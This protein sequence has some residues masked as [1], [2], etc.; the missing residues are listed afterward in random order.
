MF[1]KGSAASCAGGCGGGEDGK[2]RVTADVTSTGS[3]DGRTAV[4][5][6][7]YRCGERP[8]T[9]LTR[10]ASC[11][12]CFVEVFRRNFASNLRTRCVSRFE[13]AQP[14]IL[15]MSGN[16]FS[17]ALLHLVLDRNKRRYLRVSGVPAESNVSARLFSSDDVAVKSVVSLDDHVG[18]SVGLEEGSET[19]F[20]HVTS[21][22]NSAGNANTAYQR[23]PPR[24]QAREA[25]LLD[26]VRLS[27]IAV[28]HF[29]H[30]GPVSGSDGRNS[31]DERCERLKECLSR[32]YYESRYDELVYALDVLRALNVLSYLR[33]LGMGDVLVCTCDS[34]ELIARRVML[35][36]C[37]GAGDRVAFRSAF[38]DGISLSGLGRVVRPLK[39]FST[40]EIALYHRLNGLPEV[41]SLDLY[42]HGSPQS[43]MLGCVNS[44]LASVTTAHSS[45]LHNVCNVVEKLVPAFPG[46]VAGSVRV[47]LCSQRRSMPSLRRSGVRGGRAGKQF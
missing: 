7:C 6:P 24:S 26:S 5:G 27:H 47:G 3:S 1:G 25:M 44:L 8:A 18:T 21:V 23:L 33:E 17:T 42:W 41:E 30:T 13:G 12:E 40:K 29:T 34:Q 35:L 36:T 11:A 14:M 2:A 22:V 10:K 4:A 37:V 39:T 31:C 46:R 9:L 19:F 16:A 32:L 15:V 45:T 20:R 28:C 38:V 43:S